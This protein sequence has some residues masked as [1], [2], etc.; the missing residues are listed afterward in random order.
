MNINQFEQL[1]KSVV[2]AY[3]N[4]PLHYKY[5]RQW[6]L[7]GAPSQQYP[8]VLLER[9]PRL[10]YTKG[11]K[12]NYLPQVVECDFKVFLFDVY[13][14]NEQSSKGFSLKQ[15][16]LMKIANQVTAE[17][18]RIDREEQGH[19][20]NLRFDLTFFGDI[21]SNSNA[22]IELVMTCKADLLIDCELGEFDYGA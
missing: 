21:D 13:P 1:F 18:V 6:Y 16:E 5:N 8:C 12:N 9:M 2:E 7:N 4:R 14:L 15:S 11:L 3:K 20:L 10:K 17:M 19:K 22:L